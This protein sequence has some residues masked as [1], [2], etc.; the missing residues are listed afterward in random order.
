VA[1]LQGGISGNLVASPPAVLEPGLMKITLESDWTNNTRFLSADVTIRRLQGPKQRGSRR[2]SAVVGDSERQTF[3][4]EIPPGT[5]KASFDLS[6]QRDWT[7]FPTDDLDLILVS[8]SG[9]EDFRGA[10]FNAPERTVVD[11][12]EPGIWTAIVEGFSVHRGQAPFVLQ[13]TAE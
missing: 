7:M 10:T 12:P 13:V 6:W 9:I 8:P 2:P 1:L 4:I 5:A 3:R 11:E